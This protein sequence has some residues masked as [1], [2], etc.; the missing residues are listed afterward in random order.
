MV[1]LHGVI[2]LMDLNKTMHYRFLK[3]EKTR[4]CQKTMEALTRWLD[5]NTR[6]GCYVKNENGDKIYRNDIPVMNTR[7]ILECYE[8]INIEKHIQA[9]GVPCDACD[10]RGLRHARVIRNTITTKIYKLGGSCGKKVF[11]DEE[12]KKSKHTKQIENNEK[13]GKRENHP[14]YEIFENWRNVVQKHKTIRS[15]V[16]VVWNRLMQI[17]KEN[18]EKIDNAPYV[19]FQKWK[20]I[21]KTKR[22]R[23]ERLLNDWRHNFSR[24]LHS[25]VIDAVE[26]SN[27]ELREVKF[28]NGRYSGRRM[29]EV[30][31][32]D[33]SYALRYGDIILKRYK[34]KTR[35]EVN[36]IE[37]YN[38]YLKRIRET[39]QKM[40]Q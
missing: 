20:Y 13:R 9:D 15:N 1:E 18:R 24:T 3:D 32:E 31:I 33:P 16:I 37:A 4:P 25:T 23:K 6:E 30:F 8:P 17:S 14:L 21:V 11:S 2:R 35:Y 38:E 34:P 27:K 26:M 5:V 40:N 39:M 22:E 28:F 19:M 36:V 12:Y 10:Y 29:Y 7:R